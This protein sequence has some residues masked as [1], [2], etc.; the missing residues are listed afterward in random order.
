MHGTKRGQRRD[1]DALQRGA[2]AGPVLL[3]GLDQRWPVDV[4]ADDE[5]SA[6]ENPRVQNLRSAEPSYPLRRG[7]L[8]RTCS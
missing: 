2:A 3:D 7:D 8:F 5:R 1:R 6:F 4:L